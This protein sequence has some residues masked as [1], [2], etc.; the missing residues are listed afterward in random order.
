MPPVPELEATSSVN[1]L[2]EQKSEGQGASP[3]EGGLEDR[4]ALQVFR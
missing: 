2:S 1:A 4:I 3:Q